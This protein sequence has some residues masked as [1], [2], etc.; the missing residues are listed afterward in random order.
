MNAAFV[1]AFPTRLIPSGTVSLTPG[2]THTFLGENARQK[3]AQFVI[4]N[5]DATNLLKLQSINGVNFYTLNPGTA[6]SFFT[7]SD[8]IVYNPSGTDTVAFEAGEFFYNAGSDG[9]GGTRRGSAP[10]AT[11]AAGGGGSLG[12]G[13]GDSSGGGRYLP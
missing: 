12:P 13:P 10:G 7:D 5:C 1:K 8:I 9:G 4:C 3:R 6:A 11:A 2:A